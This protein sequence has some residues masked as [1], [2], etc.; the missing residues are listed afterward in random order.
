[1]A[2]KKAGA[3]STENSRGNKRFSYAL[4]QPSGHGQLQLK[5][6]FA[7]ANLNVVANFVRGLL[8]NHRSNI[9]ARQHGIAHG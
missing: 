6:A 9:G 2:F 8:I 3:N 4:L 1:M 5:F 7:L